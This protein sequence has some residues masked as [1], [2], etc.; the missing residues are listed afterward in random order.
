MPQPFTSHMLRV[1][2]IEIYGTKFA[3]N[4]RSI[5]YILT[6]MDNIER[7]SKTEWR[8]KDGV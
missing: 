8:V 3:G 6:R 2:M 1:H 7:A 5:G 4:T